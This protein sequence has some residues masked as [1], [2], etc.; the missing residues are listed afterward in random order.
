MQNK[1]EVETIVKELYFNSVGDSTYINLYQKAV[2]CE[3]KE[4]LLDDID[5]LSKEAI[6]RVKKNVK[7]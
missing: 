2:M 6:E 3:T 1:I 7:G 4:Q 5:V